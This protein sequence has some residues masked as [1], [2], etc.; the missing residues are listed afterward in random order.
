MKK[1]ALYSKDP[2]FLVTEP[3]VDALLKVHWHENEI[4]NSPDSS[5]DT[6]KTMTSEFKVHRIVLSR[7]SNYFLKEFK[8]LEMENPEQSDPLVQGTL[9]LALWE[10]NVAF[11]GTHEKVYYMLFPSLL[12]FIYGKPLESQ[13]VR[14]FD[15]GIWNHRTTTEK[16]HD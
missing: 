11:K 16:Q 15:F 10:V 6:S 2:L 9:Q 4:E 8:R 1:N 12:D 7:L 14:I 3:Y 5:Q 13:D